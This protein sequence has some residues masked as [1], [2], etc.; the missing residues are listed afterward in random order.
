MRTPTDLINAASDITSASEV[1]LDTVRQLTRQWS[2]LAATL[3]TCLSPERLRAAAEVAET[4]EELLQCVLDEADEL[5][6]MARDLPTEA[7]DDR[8]PW[9]Y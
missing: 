7:D 1:H 2:V 4:L 5:A 9:D 3:S 8:A 6:N